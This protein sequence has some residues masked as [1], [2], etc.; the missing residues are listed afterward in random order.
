LPSRSAGTGSGRW[1]WRGRYWVIDERP[2]EIGLADH[3]VRLV[4]RLYFSRVKKARTGLLLL[5]AT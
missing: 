2:L 5:S 1:A 4:A 3:Q